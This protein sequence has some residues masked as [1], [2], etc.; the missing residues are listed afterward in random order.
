LKSSRAVAFNLDFEICD[1]EF[2]SYRPS[3]LLT[4]EIKIAYGSDNCEIYFC[5]RQD[6]LERAPERSAA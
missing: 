3:D 1:L 2:S 5:P 6:G 4:L